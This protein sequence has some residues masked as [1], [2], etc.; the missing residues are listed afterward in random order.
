MADLTTILFDVGWPIVDE[1]LMHQ[2]WIRKLRESIGRNGSRDVSEAEIRDIEKEAIDAYVPLINPYIIWRLVGPNRVLFDRIR[3]DL[4]RHD[5]T[6]YYRLQPGIGDILRKLHSSFKLGLAANQ[7]SAVGRYL[8]LE[9]L[10]KYFVSRKVSADI[11]YAKPDIR[12]FLGVLHDI[13]SVAEETLMIGDRLD[14]DI[15]PAKSLGMLTA[16]LRLGFHRGQEPR[17]PAEEPDF[18]IESLEEI[19]SIPPVSNKSGI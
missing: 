15:V 16:W 10:A 18:R 9:G 7:P 8:E 12:M 19:L 13:G 5:F 4:D 11:G 3:A 2:E 6:P 17:Y 14:N 1:T